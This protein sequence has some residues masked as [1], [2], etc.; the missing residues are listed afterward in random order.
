[1]RDALIAF[2]IIA[3]IVGGIFFFSSDSFE[4]MTHP[5]QTKVLGGW[6]DNEEIAKYDFSGGMKA[7]E[8][9]MNGDTY[10]SKCKK[11]MEGKKR[12][13]TFCGEYIN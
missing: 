13:C 12:I 9:E 3:L 5:G 4:K 8:A 11:L 10:C 7:I 2:L 1:M 6:V